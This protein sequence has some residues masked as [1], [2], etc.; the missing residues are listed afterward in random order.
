MWERENHELNAL[1]G[2]LEAQVAAVNQGNLTRAEALLIAQAHT[3]DEMF[4]NLARQAQLYFLAGN[5]DLG[6]RYL[7]LALRH[8]A[9]VGRRWRH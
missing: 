9:N 7:R 4:N 3:L 6:E 5:F 1:V 2:E 8:R